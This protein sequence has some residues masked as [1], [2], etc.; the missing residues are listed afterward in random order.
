MISQYALLNSFNDSTAVID[1]KGYIL[2]SNDSWKQFSMN[3]SGDL[4]K[5]DV[6]VN[7]L[8]VCNTVKG[9]DRSFATN[10]AN[11]IL[12]IINGELPIFE[13]EY[14]CHS[15]E[16]QRWFILRATPIKGE[17]KLILLLHINISKRKIAEDLID[18]RNNQLNQI[19][20]RLNSTLYKIVHDIQGPL[21][22]VEG[23]TSLSKTQK[24]I[25]DTKE[26]LDLIEKSVLKL[27]EFIQ[28]TL[29]LSTFDF[30]NESIEFKTILEEIYES[31]KYSEILN[32]VEIKFDV[33]QNTRFFNNKSEII[34]IIS[35]LINNSLKYY[36][37]EKEKPIVIVSVTTNQ[38]EARIAIKDNGIGISQKFLSKIFKLKF[39]VEKSTQEGAGIGLYLV[40]KAVKLLNG[41][42][43]IDSK[44]GEGT[45]VKIVLPN[46]SNVEK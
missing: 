25:G 2:F 39:R 8:E 41:K 34:S 27:K 26:I 23:L 9:K 43:E 13:M 11:G 18:K 24:N 1:S 15:K 42:L 16:E 7:Y 36:D 6:G 32:R 4:N 33:I 17:T 46:K 21:N 10:A 31:I 35:N 45:E 29:K 3:S 28:E 14:P 40:G 19:N 12:K 22:S 37:P 38:E 30:K 44:I 5:T 20:S